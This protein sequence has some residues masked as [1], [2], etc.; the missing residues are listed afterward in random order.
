MEKYY[1]KDCNLAALQEKTVAVIGYGSQGHAHALNLHDSG[2]PVV[3]GLAPQSKSRAKAEAAGLTV[4]DVPEAVKQADVVM[5]LVPDEVMADLYEKE[6]APYLQ[7]GMLLM[8][9][10]GFNIHYEF[11]QPVAGLDVAMVA[12]KGPGHKVRSQYVEGC[13]VPSLVA[14]YQNA[15]GQA[16]SLALAYASAIGAGR[17]GILETSFKEETETD[18][19]GEQAVL[20]G[21]VTELMKV[22]FETL[23]EAGYEPE[24]AYFE[25]I[26]EMKLIVD[27]II[28]GGFA[29]MR[30]SISNTAEYGD[31]I[32]GEKVITASA[33]QA[34]QDILKDIQNGRFASDFMTEFSA[35]RKARF[36]ASRRQAADHQ[37]EAV[38]Q[39]LRSMMSWLQE[40]A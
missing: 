7:D 19:F 11:I 37:L 40:E 36:L 10:H 22:G 25:C 4:A 15:T 23:V 33:R 27:L 26:H 39:D 1:D 6:I 38:G 17:A 20:C 5:V 3:V 31:Y 12:P 13:G 34:M 32:S 2:V 9:A 16:K 29:R 14:V 24:M 30:H 21:G 28:E 18:L 35:G 8:F